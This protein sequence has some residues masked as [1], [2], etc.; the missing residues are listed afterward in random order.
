MKMKI[1]L[2]AQLASLIA[3][4]LLASRSV[5]WGLALSWPVVFYLATGD[6]ANTVRVALCSSSVLM[7]LLLMPLPWLASVV[8][9]DEGLRRAWRWRFIVFTGCDGSGKSSHSRETARWLTEHGIDAVY[10]HFFRNPLLKSLSALKKTVLKVPEE[11]AMTYTPRFREHLRAH[12]LPKLRPLVG[13]IDNWLCIS[14]VLLK[15]LLKG[16]WVVVDRYFYDFYV[17]YKCLGYPMPRALKWF[18]TRL[19]LRP[20]LV[21]VMEVR[22]EISLARRGGEHPLWYYRKALREYRALA[23]ELGAF[24]LNTERPF[25]EV[26]KDVTRL[27]SMCLR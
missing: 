21:I 11:E 9:N 15:N 19:V 14:L 26:Q 16:R 27:V 8:L 1:L 4:S 24:V 17:R 5:V 13:Y 18:Y 10:F 23:E 7:P 6:K 22:P 2:T 20:A 12:W 3:S 25:E